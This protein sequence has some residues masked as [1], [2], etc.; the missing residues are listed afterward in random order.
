MTQQAID[1]RLIGWLACVLLWGN[2]AYASDHPSWPA[3]EAAGDHAKA[4]E[5]WQ[6]AEQAYAKAVDTIE[7][8]QAGEANSNTAGLFAKLGT[9]RLHQKSFAGAETALRRALTIY[10]RTRGPDDLIVA[11]VLDLLATALFYQDDGRAL[12]GPLYYRALGIREMLLGPN[13]PEVAESLHRVAFGLY[14][15][16]GRLLSAVPVIQR[17]L[18]IQEEAFGRNHLAVANTLST[19]AAIYDAHDLR[20]TAI[21]LYE[22]ALGIRTK[23][24]GTEAVP[25]QQSLYSLSRAYYMEGRH[26]LAQR[27]TQGKFNSL[28]AQFGTTDEL[29][30]LNWGAHISTLIHGARQEA[31]KGLRKRG[32]GEEDAVP[33]SPPV[34]VEK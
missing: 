17:A 19:L 13:H 12:A 20:G 33:T 10:T 31:L 24:L 15:E 22:E 6:E 23:V 1:V 30:A 3:Y 32:G 28:E 21:P 8:V 11:D 27:L 18:A 25:T 14:F 2:I 9:M 7:D 34:I 29:M 5:A 16:E 26:D 4:V